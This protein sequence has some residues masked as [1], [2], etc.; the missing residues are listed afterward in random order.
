MRATTAACAAS[1]PLQVLFY[2]VLLVSLSSGQSPLLVACEQLAGSLLGG[3]LGIGSELGA[4]CGWHAYMCCT[5]ASIA[6]HCSQRYDWVVP[7]LCPRTWI[8]LQSFTLCLPSMAAPTK[9]VSTRRWQWCSYQ[10]G[11]GL[12]P[13]ALGSS[14]A[15]CRPAW[16]AQG[17]PA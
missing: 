14:P 3:G 4:G 12:L 9:T 11:L 2:M 15:R 6:I 17:A 10:V 1:H 13:Q 8:L 7:L 5:A 16:V